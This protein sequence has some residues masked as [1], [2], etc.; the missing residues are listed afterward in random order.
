MLISI[1]YFFIVT[2]G[3]GFITDLIVKEWK[4]DFIEKLVIRIGVGIAVIPVVGVIL[5]LLHIPLDWRIFLALSFFPFII[6]LITKKFSFKID[7]KFYTALVFLMFGITAFMYINGS[8]SYPWLEDGDPYGY[9][10]S[11]KYIAETKTFSTAFHFSHYAEPYTQGYQIFMGVLNQVNDSIYWTMKFFTSLIISL[12]ILFFFYF[13][14]RFTKNNKIALFSTF[15]LFAIPCWVSH[16]VFSLNFNMALLPVFLYALVSNKNWKFITAIIL[17]SALINHTSTGITFVI[18]MGIYYINK[19]FVEENINWDILQAGLIG[20]LLSA[21]FYIPSYLRHKEVLMQSGGIGGINLI[22]TFLDKIPF[23][24]IGLAVLLA[25]IYF[26]RKI[27]FKRKNI[28]FFAMLVIVMLVLIIPSNKIIDIKGTA[29]RDY[30]FGDFF[31]ANKENMVNNP[32]GVGIVLMT[33]FCIG[34]LIILLNY[35]KLFLKENLCIT[36]TFVLSIFSILIILGTY[37]SITIIPFRMWTFFAVFAS[38]MIGFT[39]KILNDIIPKKFQMAFISV[40]IVLVLFTSF[41]QKY[42]I[43]T[44]KWGDDRLIIPESIDLYVW[45]R[46]NLQKDSHVYP[47]CIRPEV[48]YGYDMNP[49]AWDGELAQYAYNPYYTHSLNESLE[50]NYIFLVKNDMNYVVLGASCIVKMKI[51]QTLLENRVNEMTSS[52]KFKLIHNTNTELL[53]E[54]VK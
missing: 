2:I 52:N 20:V 22:I 5:N 34:F 46:D 21:L 53:F 36:S 25:L 6:S 3:F 38:L 26:S 12:S 13:A 39:I 40:I 54:V 1:T 17:A 31:I 29:S 11:S 14:K 37:F 8:F 32:V 33:L 35:K 7:N 23:V 42:S 27:L 51:N 9:A 45:M 48:M 16:F 47:L 24:I 10:L 30:T 44:T 18:I 43:N 49:K 28:V 19:A 15:A 41:S 4:A 50:D